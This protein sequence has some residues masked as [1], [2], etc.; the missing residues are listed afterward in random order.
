[1]SAEALIGVDVGGTKI[2][3]AALVGGRLGEPRLEPTHATSSEAIVDEIVGLVRALRDS[4]DADAQAVGVGLP[5]VIDF[6]AGTA[7]SSVNIPLR[8]V[9]LREVLRERLGLPVYVDND[10]TCAALAE[11]HDEHGTLRHRN[12]VMLTVGTGVG[13]GIVIDGRVY[14]GATGAAGELGHMIIAMPLTDGVPAPSRFP[15][16]G[17]LEARAAGRALDRLARE[18][19]AASPDS[20]LG[21]AVATGQPV[22]GVQAVDAALAGDADAIESVAE[23]GRVLGIGIANVINTFDPEV[24]AIGGGVCRAGDLLLAPARETAFGY[25]LPGVGTQTEVRIAWS[26]ARAGVRGAALL[27]GQELEHEMS[28]T[29]SRIDGKV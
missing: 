3:V 2:S 23:L 20:M 1:V 16:P 13:G 29:T 22:T 24:V 10:A 11:A 5:S 7:R 21:R 19:A 18:S 12:L 9:P 17:S 26:G 4:L 14:R 28:R 27:A 25:V 15:Q 8:D 6:E